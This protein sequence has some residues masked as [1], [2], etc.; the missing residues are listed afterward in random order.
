MT[1]ETA[2]L[3]TATLGTATLETADR[4][5]A[6]GPEW[7]GLFAAGPGAQSRRPWFEA[8]EAAALPPGAR[9]HYAAWRQGG[10]PAGLLPLRAGPGR[11]AASLTSPY[12][13]LFQ[14]LLAEGAD[15]AAAGLAWGRHLRAWPTTV[16]EALDPAWPDLPALL[17]GLR[18][19]G[20]VA[21]R[22][23]HFGNWHERVAGLDWPAYLA[24]RP[25]ALRETI[26]RKRRAAEKDGAVRFEVVHGPEGL[27]GALAAYEAVYARSWKVPE[28]FP[29]FNAALLGR[30]AAA[31]SVRLGVM[32][33]GDTPV[34]AQYWTVLDGHATVLK[35]AHDD[36]YKPLSPGTLLTA[37]M[38]RGLL[39]RERV[40]AL[41]FG[42]GDD[43]YKRQW[44]GDRRQRI[45]VLLANPRRPGGVAALARHWAG[46]LR[47]QVRGPRDADAAP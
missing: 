34:A 21:A 37:H 15:A 4:V 8:T 45:G 1:L 17:R 30:M 43:P 14:P 13:V 32:W 7:D 27:D 29:G 42:R 40:Q 2:T 35:L 44:A 10:R 24:A 46:A 18:R 6:L 3:G 33:R 47:R 11:A 25:G 23:D 38:V 16:L 26:R 5:S 22:F 20:L 28:P 31:G 12:S 41:D 9:P 39:E 36:A 19:A